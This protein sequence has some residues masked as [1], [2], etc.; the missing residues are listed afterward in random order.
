M[1]AI[2][3]DRLSEINKREDKES[4]YI[5]RLKFLKSRRDKLLRIINEGRGNVE[6]EQQLEHTEKQIII[7]SNIEKGKDKKNDE[8]KEENP[9]KASEEELEIIS[10]TIVNANDPIFM[11]TR[12]LKNKLQSIIIGVNERYKKGDI[13]GSLKKIKEGLQLSNN[14]INTGKYYEQE[15]ELFLKLGEIYSQSKSR[16]DYPKAVGIY[17]YLIKLVDKLSEGIDKEERQLLIRNNIGLIEEKFIKVTR[18]DKT[19][20]EEYRGERSLKKIEKYKKELTEHRDRIIEQLNDIEDLGIVEGEEELDE[21]GLRIRTERVE[22][23]YAGIREFF[24][25]NGGLIKRLLE[26]CIKE[27]GGL[28]EIYDIKKGGKRVVKYAPFVLGSMA[29]GTMTPWSDFEWGILIEEELEKEDEQKVKEYFRNLA[30]L[31]HIKVINFGESPLRLLGVEELNNFKVSES[32]AEFNWFYD[33]FTNTGFSFDGPHWHACK[34]PLGRQKGFIKV[35]SNENGGE[36]KVECIPYELIGTI[37]EFARFQEEDIWWKEDPHLVQALWHITPILGNNKL[38]NRHYENLKKFEAI[39]IERA[40]ALLKQ[41]CLKYNPLEELVNEDKEGQILKVKKE[42]HRFTDRIAAALVKCKGSMIGQN[43]WAGIKFLSKHSSSNLRLDQTKQLLI[44]LS[45]AAE[46][47]LR[48]YSHNGSQ[49]EDLSIL[50]RYHSHLVEW[51]KEVTEKIFHLKNIKLLY[52]Y[53]YILVPLSGVISGSENLSI[54]EKN[55][56]ESDIH[57]NVETVQGF[58]YMRFLKY[59]EAIY[60]FERTD[61]KNNVIIRDNLIRLYHQTGRNYK[62]LKLCD[63]IISD[64]INQGQEIPYAITLLTRSAIL[65]GISKYE[66]ALE[67]NSRSLSIFRKHY[68]GDHTIIAIL[69]HNRGKIFHDYQIDFQ[70]ALV[71]TQ[72]ALEMR[73][74]LYQGDNIEIAQSLVNKGSILSKLGKNKE[75]LYCYEQSCEMIQRKYCGYHPLMLDILNNRGKLLVEKEEQK[76]AL[77]Y[78]QEDLRISRDLYKED[79]SIVADILSNKGAVLAK[80]G[81]YNEAFKDYNESL[82]IRK[83]LYGPDHKDIADLLYNIGNLYLNV[84]KYEESYKNIKHAKE[85]YERLKLKNR[86]YYEKYCV[87]FV[88]S[89]IVWANQEYLSNNFI[90]AEEL[91]NEAICSYN[92][93]ESRQYSKNDILRIHAVQLYNKHFTDLSLNCCEV[94]R[95]ISYISRDIHQLLLYLYL[96]FINAHKDRMGIEVYKTHLNEAKAIIKLNINKSGEPKASLKIE[97]VMFLISNNFFDS[98]EELKELADLLEG[99]NVVKEDEPEL[100]YNYSDKLTIIRPLKELLDRKCTISVK[101][102]ILAYYLLIKVYKEFEE[103]DKAKILLSEFATKV[104]D[105]KQQDAEV[106]LTLLIASCKE[107]DFDFQSRIYEK[108]LMIVNNTINKYIYYS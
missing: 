46:L 72:E 103:I 98:K 71:L 14:R 1:R 68:K 56:F 51:P 75:A 27:L 76:E 53:Y 101:P 6:V 107:L 60:N 32:D 69:L 63:E 35:K 43:I 70:K 44:A 7:I 20:S 36:I 64:N 22:E 85:M 78:F 31:M 40:F 39:I 42:I 81:K 10:G 96:S 92:L 61:Y 99:Q 52:K 102:Y 5:E 105:I 37:S 100:E 97:Y 54:F 12:D 62:A 104:M 67:N 95:G 88:R 21:E 4:S 93:T 34:T 38:I 80:L 74:R 48:T 91:Y 77:Q 90:K 66:E 25:G 49:R 24:I 47:R 45:T 16:L 73:E 82:T 3:K 33:N 58:I 26:D 55:Y 23:I 57:F 83:K 18:E 86:T 15:Y 94:L 87:C 19:T 17:H 65:D 11:D 50:A 2:S 108:T 13:G 41:D 8:I 9:S 84:R 79:S 30:V 59:E 29:L 106:P 89:G 28:P